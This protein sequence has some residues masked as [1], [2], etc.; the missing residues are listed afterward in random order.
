MKPMPMTNT[1]KTA[2]GIAAVGVLSMA[3][4]GAMRPAATTSAAAA[5]EGSPAA[6]APAAA[7]DTVLAAAKPA[8]PRRS[9]KF[10]GEWEQTSGSVKVTCNGKLAKE[11]PVAGKHFRVTEEGGMLRFADNACEFPMKVQGSVA[12]AASDTCAPKSAGAPPVKITK[13]T[14]ESDGEIAKV[15]FEGKFQNTLAKD[16]NKVME[17]TVVAETAAR[18]L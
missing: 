14:L 13:Q 2:L 4:Y 18:R 1:K 9:G 15:A 11:V 8:T 7:G 3:A 6:A 12:S 16:G 5:S 10:V 17:C